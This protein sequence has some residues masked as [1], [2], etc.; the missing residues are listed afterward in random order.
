MLNVRTCGECEECE[1]IISARRRSFSAANRS[2]SDFKRL[3]SSTVS[4]QKKNNLEHLL[5]NSF[6]FF[7]CWILPW[8]KCCNDE[9][10]SCA[11]LSWFWISVSRLYSATTTWLLVSF[12]SFR[13][14]TNCSFNLLHSANLIWIEYSW[15][16]CNRSKTS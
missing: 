6:L 13:K 7:L 2:I 9:I 12:N 4:E 16:M 14:S 11:F 5:T 10:S 15:L 8:T 1:C 3:D